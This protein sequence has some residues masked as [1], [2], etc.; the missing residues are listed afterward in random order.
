MFN[1]HLL[2]TAIFCSG[3]YCI[4]IVLSSSLLMRCLLIMLI[5]CITQMSDPSKFSVEDYNW[6]DKKQV[7]IHFKYCSPNIVKK[8]PIRCF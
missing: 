7:I 8:V 6:F 5:V 2:Y 1:S 4:K 3:I